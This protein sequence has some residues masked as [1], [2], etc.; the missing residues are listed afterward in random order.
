M[1]VPDTVT[2]K[3]MTGKYVINK[4]LSDS[5][6]STLKMQNVGFIV[7]QAAQYS[8]IIVELKQ[9]T[10]DKGTMHLKQVQTSL[11][12][13]TN[14]EER[15][16]NGEWGEADNAIWG[17]VKGW[18]RFRKVSEIEDPFQKEGWEQ[19][20]IDGE[21][22]E[23][24]NESMTDSWNSLVVYGFAVIDGVRRHVRRIVSK[25]GKQ[26]EKIRMVYDWQP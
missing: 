1:S 26:V 6:N 18:T 25:K 22:I 17:K 5:S 20:C 24:Y 13:I 10:D 11:G 16:I 15:Q 2:T 21:V 23:A 4:K 19:A 12:G 3:D 8:T 7:R 9:Y 14:S